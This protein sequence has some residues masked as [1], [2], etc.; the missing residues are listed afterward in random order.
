MPEGRIIKAISGYYYVLADQETAEPVQCRARG[1]F[2]KKE[3]VP[4]VGDRVVFH[5]EATG[6][7]TVDE[8]FPRNNEL[9]RPPIANVNLAVLVFSIDEPSLNLQLL[10][11][12]LVHIEWAGIPALICLT[13]LDLLT[14]ANHG[15]ALEEEELEGIQ[16]IYSRIGYEVLSTSA[17]TSDGLSDLFNRLSGKISVFS[18][19]SGVGKSTLLNELIPGLELKTNA[20]S[21]KLGRGKHTT[22]HVELLPIHGGGL[23]ADTPG[24]SQLDFAQ[25]ESE[26][27]GACFKEFSK[28][29]PSCKYRGCLHQ[30]EPGCGVLQ[31]LDAGEISPLRYKHY[32]HFLQEI[33]ERKRRY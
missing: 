7:G 33:K 30:T 22:R 5:T 11:K 6:E 9:T 13:K 4:L 14:H 24:F 32:S 31:A 20:I 10:D 25:I 23:V 17:R 29:I 26:E 1:L 21:E 16:S 3:I 18:G 2:R 19:Q 27:L 28:F 15:A 12:F 8:L